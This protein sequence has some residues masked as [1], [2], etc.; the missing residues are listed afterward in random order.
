M[1]GQTKVSARGTRGLIARGVDLAD[2][3]REAAESLDGSGGGHNIASGA[4]IP[5]G[6]EEKFLTLV[7]EIVGRQLSASEKAQ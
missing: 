6:K 4:T 5:K 1:D 2:A 3:L 7:D